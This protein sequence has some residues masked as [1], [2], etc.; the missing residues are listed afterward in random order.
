MC[1]RLMINILAGG[2]RHVP[3]PNCVREVLFHLIEIVK[4]L[5]DIE[6]PKQQHEPSTSSVQNPLEFVINKFDNK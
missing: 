5:A 3:K 1:V 4:C 6:V 2:A